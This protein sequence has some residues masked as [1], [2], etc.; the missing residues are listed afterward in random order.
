MA[1]VM[2]LGA[3]HA[4]GK[5]KAGSMYDICQV[6]YAIPIQSVSNDNRTVNGYGNEEQSIDL[7]PSALPTFGAFK[8]GQMI[9]LTLGANPKNLQRNICTGAVPA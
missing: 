8:P 6:K 1:K 9:E 7:D 5:S 2:Y 3:M 4:K